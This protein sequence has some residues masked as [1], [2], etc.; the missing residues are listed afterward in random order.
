[1]PTRWII[2]IAGFLL[3]SGLAS[4]G[5]ETLVITIENMGIAPSEASA[6]VGDTVQRVNNDVFDHTANARNGD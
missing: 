1:M 3:L 5:G 4:A 6:K 2:P